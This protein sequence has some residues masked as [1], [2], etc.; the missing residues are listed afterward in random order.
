MGFNAKNG[1]E[2]SGDPE[3]FSSGGMGRNL[4]SGDG[5]LTKNPVIPPLSQGGN[6]SL[7]EV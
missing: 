5:D 7:A 6:F 3:I 2:R 4:I 1:T